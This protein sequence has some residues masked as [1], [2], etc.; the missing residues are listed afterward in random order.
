M[1]FF[2]RVKE[3]FFNSKIKYI[4]L[5]SMSIVILVA[6]LFIAED[7]FKRV[8]AYQDAF[9][10]ASLFMLGF[11]GLSALGNLGTFDIFSYSGKYVFNRMRGKSVE[12][13]HEFIENKSETRKTNK[14]GFGPFIVM[15]LLWMIVALILMII[16]MN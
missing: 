3:I 6:M 1:K 5:I 7:G 13:Y 10:V 15:G 12:R 9:F 8:A 2:K 11:G 16:V 4:I 14:Y